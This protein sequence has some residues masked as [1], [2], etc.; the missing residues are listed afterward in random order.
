MSPTEQ[1][2]FQLPAMG[3]KWMKAAGLVGCLEGISKDRLLFCALK[4]FFALV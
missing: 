4:V 1:G 3:Q 2:G